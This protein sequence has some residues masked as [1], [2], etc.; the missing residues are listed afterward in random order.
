MNFGG[1]IPKFWY[2]HIRNE[3]PGI[4]RPCAV[5]QAGTPYWAA[6]RRRRYF[7]P[8]LYTLSLGSRRHF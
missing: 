5:G 4:W 7:F 8:V 1:P 6:L 3:A 2:G